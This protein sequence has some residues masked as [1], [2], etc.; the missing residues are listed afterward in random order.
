MRGIPQGYGRR[1]AYLIIGLVIFSFGIVLTLQAHI[2]YSPWD[3]LHSGISLT[4]GISIG[5]V[6][7]IVGVLIGSVVW[8]SG[9][10][11]GIGSILNM[12]M[13][14]LLMDLFLATNLIP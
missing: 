13:V 4:S 11:F 5:L 2:G 1:L 3:I 12:V 6:S 7:T 10:E 8:F 9:E 14:G